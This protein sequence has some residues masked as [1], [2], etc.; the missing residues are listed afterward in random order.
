MR[1]VDVAGALAPDV[2]HT[3]IGIRPGEKLHEVLV[4]QDDAPN[5]ME[6]EDRFVILPSL[7]MWTS[8]RSG[9]GRKVCPGFSYSSDNNPQKL[10]SQELLRMLA[11]SERDHGQ[12]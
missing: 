1:V 9:N 6:Q 12:E 8:A 2:P 11:E 4:T 10:T 7:A 5:V 3:I